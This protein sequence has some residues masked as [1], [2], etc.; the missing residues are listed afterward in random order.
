M[1]LSLADLILAVFVGLTSAIHLRFAEY[2]RI[3]KSDSMI[4]YSRYNIKSILTGY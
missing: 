1:T 4:Y 2:F 3:N